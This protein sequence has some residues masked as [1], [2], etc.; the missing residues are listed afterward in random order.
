MGL[1]GRVRRL[2]GPREPERCPE[3]GD[4]I[5]YVEHHED[6]T[7]TYP[8]GEP[9]GACGSRPPGGGIGIMEVC[10]TGGSEAG[11]VSFP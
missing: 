4:R 10:P 2:E 9:C 3:C 1:K 7:T 5:V 11:D 6:G 8:F